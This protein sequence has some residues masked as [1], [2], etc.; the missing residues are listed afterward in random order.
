M[1]LYLGTESCTCPQLFSCF[2]Y[3]LALLY[4]GGALPTILNVSVDGAQDRI[5]ALNCSPAAAIALNCSP[6][7][8]TALNCCY[9]T[10]LFSCCCYCSA[11]ACCCTCACACCRSSW[12]PVLCAA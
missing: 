5:H 1:R 9:C 2:A 11:C 8:A 12:F 7:A 4:R 10:Q 3:A 6:A